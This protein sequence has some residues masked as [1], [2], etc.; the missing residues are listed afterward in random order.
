[1]KLLGN[2]HALSGFLRGES[3]IV[4]C[5]GGGLKLFALGMLEAID[6]TNMP[7]AYAGHSA[8]ICNIAGKQSGEHVVHR[9][10]ETYEYLADGGFMK[11]TWRGPRFDRDELSACLDNQRPG[12]PGLNMGNIQHHPDPFLVI[13]ADH[14]KGMS[15]FF[16]GKQNT[17]QLIKG[18]VALPHLRFPVM[19]DGRLRSDGAYAHDVYPA[20]QCIVA[21]RELRPRNLVL[22]MNRFMSEHKTYMD[23]IVYPLLECIEMRCLPPQLRM[24]HAAAALRFKQETDRLR[25]A[26]IIKWCA[27]APDERDIQIGSLTHT[28]R[29]MRIAREQGRAFAHTML[30][31]AYRF[32]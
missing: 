2:L 22:L 17:M 8:G 4:F 12:V 10:H 25:R 26:R 1:M 23:R 7:A 21:F 19:I 6:D 15:Q 14:E 16:N 20:Q 9:I 13:V 32:A 24:T 29:K 30:E 5:D 18:G 3:T 27:L 28:V 31:A 11:M